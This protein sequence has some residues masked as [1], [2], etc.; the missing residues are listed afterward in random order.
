MSKQSIL[1]GV[2]TLGAIFA[3]CSNA[4][5]KSEANSQIQSATVVTSPEDTTKAKNIFFVDVRTPG[6]FAQGSV[7]GAVNIPLDQVQNRIGEFKGKEEIV[8]FCRSG[9]RSSQAKAILEQ[10]GITN[11]IN[12]GSWEDVKKTYNK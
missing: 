4:N 5:G 1:I 12:G 2:I 3:S 10:N 8:V 11:V 7:T 9:N 6:E